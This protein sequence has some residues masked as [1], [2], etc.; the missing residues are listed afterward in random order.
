[1]RETGFLLNFLIW[2]VPEQ[3]PGDEPGSHESMCIIDSARDTSTCNVLLPQRSTTYKGASI[4][5]GRVSLRQILQRN[6]S[7][8]YLLISPVVP[9]CPADQR[10]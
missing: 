6:V 3:R 2:D 1:M 7:E 8:F 5:V 9:F 4:R 10:R